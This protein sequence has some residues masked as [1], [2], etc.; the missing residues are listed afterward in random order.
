MQGKPVKRGFAR[1]Y[2]QLSFDKAVLLLDWIQAL[3]Y[4]GFKM[5]PQPIEVIAYMFQNTALEVHKMDCKV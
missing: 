2:Q 5:L 4:M 3:T 1:L